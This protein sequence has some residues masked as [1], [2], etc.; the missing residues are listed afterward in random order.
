MAKK[1]RPV[2]LAPPPEMKSR[3]RARKVTSLFHK[4]TREL[5]E[6]ELEDDQEKIQTLQK[7]I[8]EMGGRE[9]YQRASQLST[10]FHSTSKWVLKVIREK[11]WLNGRTTR[12]I[13]TGLGQDKKSPLQILEIGAINTELIDASKHTKRILVKDDNNKDTYQ[14]DL[15]YNICV[16]AIDL[17]SMHSDIEEQDFLKMP[18]LDEMGTYDVIVCSMVLNCVPEARQRGTFLSL[19]YRQLKPG[20]LVF[21]TIPKLC[22]TQSKYTNEKLVD[23]ILK[24]GVGFIIE[25]KTDTPKVQFWV[26]KRGEEGRK[27]LEWKDRWETK[28]LIN[29]GKKYRNEFSIVL[30]QKEVRH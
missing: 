17:N 11:G 25:S 21:F 9:E 3:K 7:Q 29:H 5:A 1:K 28:K 10:K 13:Q 12:K 19:M 8:E 15:V 24:D 20:G 27:H 16:R 18:V 6:A 26:L 30:M 14:H 23:E 2:P 22:L 4:L